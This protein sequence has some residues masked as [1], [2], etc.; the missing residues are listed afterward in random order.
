M[1]HSTDLLQLVAMATKATYF[2]ENLICTGD[3][4]GCSKSN[5]SE[6]SK[7]V[8]ETPPLSTCDSSSVLLS[9]QSTLRQA[10]QAAKSARESSKSLEAVAT[11][12]RSHRQ[13]LTRESTVRLLVDSGRNSSMFFQC[14]AHL[15]LNS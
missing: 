12:W 4:A 8:E 2:R 14:L 11:K 1:E 5:F 9:L 3:S 10:D 6:E 15:P 7:E 13:I